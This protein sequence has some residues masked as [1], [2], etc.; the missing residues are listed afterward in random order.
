MGI[1]TSMGF[2]AFPRGLTAW[3]WYDD[4]NTCR[5][6]F[7]L[8][9]TAN[10]EPKNWHGI[11]VSPGSRVASVKKLAEE[12]GLTIKNVRTSLEKLKTTNYLAIKATNKYSVISIENWEIITGRDR[13]TGKQTANKYCDIS[14]N[15]HKDEQIC[16]KQTA[17]KYNE[18]SSEIIEHHDDVGKQPANNRQTNGNQ[19]ATTK[20]LKQ[21]NNITSSFPLPPSQQGEAP[22]APAAPPQPPPSLDG[23]ETS[24][25]E[26]GLGRRMG[27]V[28]QQAMR[29]YL[30]AGL[31][32]GLIAQAMREAAEHDVKATLPYIRSILDRCQAQGIHTLEAWQAAHRGSGA[33]KRVDRPI[34]SGNNFLEDA[35]SRPRR[36]K[37]KE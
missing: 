9:L 20:P 17:S 21:I 31:E 7:H 5:L 1:D 3:E 25:R 14:I 15:S 18:N 10:W 11:V 30:A 19:L 32:E 23:L 35:M 4:P 6:F 37:R 27:P 12:T 13:L 29:S 24:W 33:Q 22:Q 34:P 36:H 8:M 2:V 28:V 16:G 26:L